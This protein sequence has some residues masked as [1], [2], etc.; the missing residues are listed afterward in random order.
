MSTSTQKSGA[1]NICLLYLLTQLKTTGYHGFVV[2]PDEDPRSFR[3]WK[4]HIR[5]RLCEAQKLSY[6]SFTTALFGLESPNPTWGLPG[7]MIWTGITSP[8]WE[9]EAQ[10]IAVKVPAHHAQRYSCKLIRKLF[11]KGF[12][13]AVIDVVGLAEP[14][15]VAGSRTT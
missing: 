9:G 5:T 14:F 3:L 6:A 4:S 1:A 15:A 10:S 8:H 2:L 11:H 7:V 13:L 12:T